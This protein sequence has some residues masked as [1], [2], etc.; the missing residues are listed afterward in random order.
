[1]YEFVVTN[2]AM[3]RAAVVAAVSDDKTPVH[4]HIDGTNFHIRANAGITASRATEILR[5]LRSVP[6]HILRS[7][8][9]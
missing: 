9:N 4:I 7:Q 2:K 3:L 8:E 1:M 5:N 6:A